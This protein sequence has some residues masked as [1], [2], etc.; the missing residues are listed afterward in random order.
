MEIYF[1][2]YVVKHK[3][4]KL[5]SLPKN[6]KTI[7]VG[8]YSQSNAINCLQGENIQYLNGK[9]NQLTAFYWLWKNSK[10]PI[11]GVNHYRRFFVNDQ[12]QILTAP[13]IEDILSK[14]NDAICHHCELSWN[15]IGGNCISSG[16]SEGINAFNILY[17]YFP[18]D[19]EKQFNIVMNS[20]QFQVANLIIT[21]EQI[22]KDY[23]KWLFSFIINAANQFSPRIYAKEQARRAMGFM[24]EAMLSIWLMKNK[25][26]IFH[27]PCIVLDQ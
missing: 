11:I 18:R 20:N 10:D 5:P 16:L 12:K 2:I 13:Q 26:K 1:M 7:C 22:F 23:C 17:K 21:S 4:Y 24:G 27:C 9:I 19:Y 6:Y 25:I 15:S 14:G 8:G 3:P